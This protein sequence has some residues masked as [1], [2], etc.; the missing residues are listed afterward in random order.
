VATAVGVVAVVVV[1]E[2]VIIIIISSSSITVDY[3]G[4]LTA[5]TV[6]NIKRG[7]INFRNLF[8]LCIDCLIDVVIC[9]ALCGK[10]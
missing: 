8:I 1:V 3:D 2:G 7:W 6:K 9:C 10:R 4:V 5:K